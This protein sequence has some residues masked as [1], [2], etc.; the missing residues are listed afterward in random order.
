MF[1]PVGHY[2]FDCQRATSSGIQVSK[3]DLHISTQPIKL[4]T[5]GSQQPQRIFDDLSF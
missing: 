3:P 2:V 1:L 4:L 5:T